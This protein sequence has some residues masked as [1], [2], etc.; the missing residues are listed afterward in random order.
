MRKRRTILY[1]NRKGKVVNL[2]SKLTLENKIFTRAAVLQKAVHSCQGKL[3]SPSADAYLQTLLTLYNMYFY[4][5]NFLTY[6]ADENPLAAYHLFR[7]TRAPIS[8]RTPVLSVR[9]TFTELLF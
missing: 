5:E 2:S 1:T 3:I 6:C 4:R 9:P 8:S 7:K